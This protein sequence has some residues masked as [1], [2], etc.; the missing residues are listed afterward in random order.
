MQA[1]TGIEFV[2]N[3]PKESPATDANEQWDSRVGHAL[4]N[5]DDWSV[6]NRSSLGRLIEKVAKDAQC[7][8]PAKDVGA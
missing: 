1:L 5:L 8:F 6:L 7:E 4:R 3:L 2:M